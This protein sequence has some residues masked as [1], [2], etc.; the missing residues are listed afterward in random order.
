MKFSILVSLAILG[1]TPSL[2]ADGYCST[3]SPKN[4][5]IASGGVVTTYHLNI[6][7]ISNSGR[8]STSCIM[9]TGAKGS[10]VREVQEACNH[11]YGASLDVDGDYGAKTK[12]AV[13][14]M[15]KKLG[16]KG[17]D[18]DGIYGP[19]TGSLMN[20]YGWSNRDWRCVRAGTSV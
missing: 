16:L 10:G 5:N 7:A 2:A 13:K 20:F 9:N 3:T 15:Q 8:L 4:I 6:P 17:D 11:C 18:V 19:Q 1:I 14:S 12:A